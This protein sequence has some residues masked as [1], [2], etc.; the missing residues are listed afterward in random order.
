MHIFLQGQREAAKPL[1][2]ES[3]LTIT[4][5]TNLDVIEIDAASNRRIEEIRD[6]R[7]KVKYVSISSKYKVYIIDEVHML[8]S[9]AFNALLKTLEE[10]FSFL[11]QRHLK[12]F[13]QRFSRDVNVFILNRFRWKDLCKK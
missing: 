12:R 4:N 7:E 11:L 5:G 13:R 2:L 1:L 9:F 8:T 3:F 10:W 6:L